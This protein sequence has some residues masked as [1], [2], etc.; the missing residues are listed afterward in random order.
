MNQKQLANVLLKVLGVSICVHGLPA[1]AL[2]FIGAFEALIRAMQDSH[3]T[4]SSFPNWTYSLSYW[5]QSVVVFVAGILL[6]IRSRWLVEKLFKD[7]Q[8]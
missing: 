6:I 3:A 2:A 5:I 8:E 4:G 1:F 7:E